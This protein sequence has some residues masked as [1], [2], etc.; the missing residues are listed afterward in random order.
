MWSTK[1]SVSTPLSDAPRTGVQMAPHVRLLCPLLFTDREKEGWWTWVSGHTPALK[2][3]VPQRYKDEMF[4]LAI[5]MQDMSAFENDQDRLPLPVRDSMNRTIHWFIHSIDPSAFTNEIPMAVRNETTINYPRFGFKLDLAANEPLFDGIGYDAGFI[6]HPPEATG[7]NSWG[8]HWH[9]LATFPW[10]YPDKGLLHVYKFE[11]VVYEI[12]PMD[13]LPSG[14]S[15]QQF[16]DQI[17]SDP[18][19]VMV[20][21]NFIAQSSG[22]TEFPADIPPGAERTIRENYPYSKCNGGSANDPSGTGESG[23]GIGECDDGVVTDVNLPWGGPKSV[24]CG[25]YGCECPTSIGNC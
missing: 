24:P 17:L 25:N 7:Q 22:P 23:W 21:C 5:Y 13:K 8:N 14:M 18:K 19:K 15:F 4:K 6:G 3:A 1:S 12:S 16:D 11:M 2:W 9:G 20:K 10:G